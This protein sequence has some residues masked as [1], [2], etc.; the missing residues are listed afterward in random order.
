MTVH[1]ELIFE[2]EEDRVD[3]LVAIAK[4]AMENA[5]ALNVPLFVD[6]GHG[7]SWGDCKG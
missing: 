1:D 6:G 3:D 2:C 7:R 5:V 4:P